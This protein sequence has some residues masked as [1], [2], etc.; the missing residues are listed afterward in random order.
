MGSFLYGRIGEET[1]RKII[2]IMLGF[3]GLFMI[4]K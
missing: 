1:F 3:L 2:L 4:F